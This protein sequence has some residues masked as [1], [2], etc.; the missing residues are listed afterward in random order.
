LN[1]HSDGVS[2][3]KLVDARI[4]D[5]AADIDIALDFLLRR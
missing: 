5:R 3:G 1:Q 2:A 4:R